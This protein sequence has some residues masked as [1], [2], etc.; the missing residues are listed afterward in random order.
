MAETTTFDD[1]GAATVPVVNRARAAIISG[2]AVVWN[3][4][5]CEMLVPALQLGPQF[6]PGAVRGAALDAFEVW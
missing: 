1:A 4:P 5:T 2:T 3:R 6:D